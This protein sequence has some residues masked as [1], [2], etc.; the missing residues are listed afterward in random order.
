MGLKGFDYGEVRINKQVVNSKN[1]FKILE[2]RKW[3][4]FQSR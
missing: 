4:H 3:Q 2:K 1:H